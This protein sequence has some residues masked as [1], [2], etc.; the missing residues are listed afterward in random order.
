[1][2]GNINEHLDRLIG[3]GLLPDGVN[4]ETVKELDED[5]YAHN[6]DKSEEEV[7]K[8]EAQKQNLI[9]KEVIDGSGRRRKVWVRF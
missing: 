5:V 9:S 4:L 3:L 2:D 7:T 6:L 1:M 8:S